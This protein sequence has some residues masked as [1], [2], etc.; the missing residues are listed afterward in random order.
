MRTNK[1]I[2]S[3]QRINQVPASRR[4]DVLELNQKCE[5]DLLKVTVIGLVSQERCFMI[6]GYVCCYS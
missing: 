3:F 1:H 2:L 5:V 4:L 6:L